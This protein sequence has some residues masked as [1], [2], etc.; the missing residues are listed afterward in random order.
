MKLT[1]KLAGAALGLALGLAAVAPAQADPI[2]DRTMGIASA[3][4]QIKYRT[5]PDAQADAMARLKAQADA[6]VAAAPARA[7]P[8]VWDGIVTSTLAGLKGGMGGLSL[9]KE[10][11]TLLE[12]AEKI[13][14]SALDGSAHTSLGALY[15]QVPGWPIGFGNKDKAKAELMAGLKANPRGADANYFWGD[16]LYNQGQYAPAAAALKT[17]L[18]APA[19]PG[20]EI[21]DAGRRGE[22]QK[23]LATVDAKLKG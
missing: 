18:A 4:A 9:A 6:A 23:L 10:A 22:I 5:A 17:A 8:L 19:R 21:A 3:W 15:Y 11:K 7:E 12:R 13:D 20:R 16:F 2:F 14:G 1:V